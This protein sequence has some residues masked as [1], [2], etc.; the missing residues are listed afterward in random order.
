M[1]LVLFLG[2]LQIQID[3][4]LFKRSTVKG[5]CIK[6]K[7]LVI[8]LDNFTPKSKRSRLSKGFYDV[9]KFRS[10]SASQAYENYFME[11]PMLVERVLDQGSFL[12]TKISK[13]F[14]TKDWNF[15][16]S[17][18]EEPYENMVKEFFANAI[19]E[20]DE[21]KCWVRGQHSIVTPY[22]LANILYINWPMFPK[23][24]VY[25]NLNLDEEFL[26]DFLRENLE[27]S[28]NGKSI[29]VSSLSP[30]LRVFTAIMF[31]NL[32]PLS[33][34][35]YMN[36]G[37]ALFLHDLITDEEI[38]ICSHIFHILRKTVARTASRHYIPFGCLISRI[39][40]LK[41]IHPSDDESPYSK[42]SPI[43]I[44]TLNASIGHSQ[45]EIKIESLAP[46]GDPCLALHGGSRFSSQSYDEKLDNIMASVQD[47][48]TKLSRLA[49]L[50]Y[51]HNICC[52]MKFTSLQTQLD[53]I[54]RKL[55]ENED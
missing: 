47:I 46:H 3:M 20:G 39:L 4:S 50:L 38:D 1:W 14:S 19:S 35:G 36:L 15:L 51:S 17:N 52:D 5:G 40:K 44:H 18:L 32:Y 12:D 9:S 55:E 48:N 21:L 7:E 28:L 53:Q 16:L 10:Y 37:R 33:S 6:G 26:W 54:Q 34:I 27:F 49:S 42:P 25:D 41:G 13:W 43:S 2:S 22:Y 31:H 8:D 11:A 24:L 23:P 45:K 30:E 29:S